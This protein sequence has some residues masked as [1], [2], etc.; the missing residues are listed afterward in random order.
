MKR[1]QRILAGVVVLGGAAVLVSYAFILNLDPETRAGL[2]GDV[3]E[4]L[5]PAYVTSMLLAAVGFF[6]YT[7]YLLFR[8]DPDGVRIA[9]RFGYGLFTTFYVLILGPS[10]LW[11][12]FTALMVQQPGSPL[13]LS[14]ML[15]LAIVGLGSLGMLTALLMLQP[16][17]PVRAYWLAVGG[18]LAFCFQTVVLDLLVWTAYFPA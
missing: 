10:A 15:V 9:G 1:K 17:R 7:S 5:L 4:R 18:T 13:W 16:R 12:P 8:V 3:P 6:A 11:L 14:I 2:W